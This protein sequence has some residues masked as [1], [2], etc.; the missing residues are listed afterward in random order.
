VHVSDLLLSFIGN[1]FCTFGIIIVFMIPSN[2]PNK[3]TWMSYVP[4]GAALR[5]YIFFKK[6]S[7]DYSMGDRL[8]RY[9]PGLPLCRDG[10]GY[11]VTDCVYP[12]IYFDL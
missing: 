11:I 10:K 6:N 1:L 5:K 2:L 12:A 3:F 7:I 8:P 9:G 4:N